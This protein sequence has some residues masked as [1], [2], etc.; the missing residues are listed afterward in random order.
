MTH[1]SVGIP[2]F[3]PLSLLLHDLG[4]LTQEQLWELP[5]EDAAT[6][7]AGIPPRDTHELAHVSSFGMSG[8]SQLS[9]S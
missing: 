4:T 8:V 5:F 1:L 2:Y 7:V 3:L 6:G 9:D